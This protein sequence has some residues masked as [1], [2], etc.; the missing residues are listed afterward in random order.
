MTSFTFAR[1]PHIE[2]GAGKT[3]R[4]PEIAGRFGRTV[5]LV[6]G[7]ESL[8][9]SGRWEALTAALEKKSVRYFHLPVSGEPSPALVDEAVSAYKDRDIGAVAAIGGG[10]VVDAGKAVS[11]MLLQDGPVTRYLEGV[12]TGEVHDGRKVPFVAVP[13][14][15]GTGSEAT[16]NAV[17]SR[18]GAAGFKKSLRHDNFVPDVALVD[19]A[20]MLSCPPDI[21]AAC[22]MDALTQ[23]LESY[24][25]SNANPMTDALALSGLALAAKNLMPA[26]SAGASDVNVRGGMA[27]ASLM[28]GITLA[29]AGLGV[30]H[31][32]AAVIGGYFEIPHGVVCGTLLAQATKI[33]I[34]AL[35][36]ASPDHRALKKYAKAGFLLSGQAGEN[37]EAGCEALI[38]ILHEWTE[39]LELPLLSD[40]GMKASDAAR[41]AAGAGNKNNPAALP[42]DQIEA[43]LRSRIL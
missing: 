41:V 22:G 15:A 43:L 5:L 28:S 8:K 12:G 18:V 35:Q 16:K 27:Y 1:M 9:E 40:F 3:A 10:S 37:T 26:C 32:L 30:I 33:T 14:T 38:R 7:R 42:P 20:L 24:V 34:E 17:L 11:A 4:L 25:S 39:T 31:G 19:P 29:S 21:T 36:A 13:T 6:T 23:L 2:F